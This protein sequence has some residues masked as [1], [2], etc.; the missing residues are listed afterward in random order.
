LAEAGGYSI[1]LFK[2]GWGILIPHCT[3][4]ES[5]NATP[6]KCAMGNC[7]SS[8]QL[9]VFMLIAHHKLMCMLNCV[10]GTDGYA[11]DVSKL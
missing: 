10:A 11:I 2:M 4:A 3:S 6:Y 9:A 8:S 5:T 1:E 7:N